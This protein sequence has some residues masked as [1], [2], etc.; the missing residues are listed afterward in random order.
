M[1][2]NTRSV[3]LSCHAHLAAQMLW[4]VIR[5]LKPFCRSRIALSG[6]CTDFPKVFVCAGTALSSLFLNPIVGN[7]AEERIDLQ[8][9]FENS[10]KLTN[11]ARFFLSRMS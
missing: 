10:P 2:P 3:L 6:L 11:W 1:G 8:E 5:Y 9:Y 4:V 7:Q